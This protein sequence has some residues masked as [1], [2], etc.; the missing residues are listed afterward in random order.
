MKATDY[1][2]EI[3][4]VD[5]RSTDSNADTMGQPAVNLL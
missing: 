5:D 1:D 4:V 2:Y 3:I